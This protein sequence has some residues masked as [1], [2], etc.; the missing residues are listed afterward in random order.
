[1]L[2]KP[3]KHADSSGNLL[4]ISLSYLKQDLAWILKQISTGNVKQNNW[5]MLSAVLHRGMVHLGRLFGEHSRSW[6]CFFH[7]L[8]TPANTMT[9][10]S[11]LA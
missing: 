9:Q 8:Q 7:A 6:S 1:M 3:M 10:W 2:H 4:A 5:F 11:T